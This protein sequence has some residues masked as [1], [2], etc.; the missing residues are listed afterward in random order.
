M[1]IPS[2]EM[3]NKLKIPQF[4]FGVFLIRDNDE[5]EKCC[6]EAFKLGY[7]HIDTSHVYGNEKGVGEAIR[8]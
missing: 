2:L 6:L 3:N 8:K 1:S 7:R 4:G 5:A